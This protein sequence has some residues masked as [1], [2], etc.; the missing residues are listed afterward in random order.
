MKQVPFY[1]NRPDDMSC[2]LACIRSA[3]EYFTDKTYSWEEME[4]LIGFKAG[5][6]AW[7]VKIWTHLAKQGF[8]IH[9]IEAFDYERYQTEGRAY[10]ESYLKPEELEWQLKHSNLLE[11]GPQLTEFL[12]LVHR[13]TRSPKLSDIDTM[14]AEGRLVTVGVDSKTLNNQPGYTSHMILVHAKEGEEYIAH[15]P[16]LQPHENRRIPSDLL[17]KAMGGV[18]NRIEVTGIKLR[19]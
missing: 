18:G 10:L 17:F 11:I 13:E 12:Q 2:M 5:K 1:P 9:V 16:G 15:D 4:E 3:M 8:D 14:L 19:K 7:T 6:A